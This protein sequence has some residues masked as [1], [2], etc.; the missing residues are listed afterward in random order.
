MNQA[1]IK[2]LFAKSKWVRCFFMVLFAIVNY[3][4]QMLVWLIAIFQFIVSLLTGKVNDNLKHFG[5]SLSLYS[6]QILQFLAYVDDHKP[7]PFA[8]WPK[9]DKTSK[10]DK[11]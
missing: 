4:L 7:Y 5:A 9:A 2:K 1:L 3:F 8:K 10:T 11:S 6:C